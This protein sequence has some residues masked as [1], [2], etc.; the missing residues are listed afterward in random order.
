M[1]FLTTMLLWMMPL[2]VPPSLLQ[3]FA[4]VAA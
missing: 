3:L 4:S 2:L 1:I